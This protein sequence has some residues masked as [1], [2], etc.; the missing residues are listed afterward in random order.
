MKYIYIIL[1]SL[2]FISSY[3]QVKSDSIYIP[4]NLDESLKQLD[5]MFSAETKDTIRA[6]SED[7]FSARVH[8]GLGM[9]LRNGWG[10]WKGSELSIFFN[11]LG[12]EHPDDMTGII[13]DSYHR[14]LLGKNINL[15]QQVLNYK[16][17][18]KVV[19][20]PDKKKY[21]KG[22]R[23]LEF[24]S[25]MYYDSEKNGQGYVHVG[26]IKNSSEIWLYDYYYG[27]LKVNQ[28]DLDNLTANQNDRDKILSNLKQSKA[29]NSQ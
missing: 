24:N 9:S 25:G 13:F 21:P 11:G 17:Y 22:V 4:K 14:Y 26:T 29:P 15:E 12:I 8:L 7:D 27:W 1:L 20:A 10:L 2:V 19:V 6:L 28:K 3:S 18:W 5:K 16:N 23:N